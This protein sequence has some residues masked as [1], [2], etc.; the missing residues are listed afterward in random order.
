MTTPCSHDDFFRNIW[1]KA[2]VFIS[3][4]LL[5]Q[6]Y[7]DWL[8]EERILELLADEAQPDLQYGFN[9]DVTAYNGQ[10]TMAV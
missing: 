5:R 7:S 3:R 1:Q 2:P 9:L 6:W 4:P 10:V 8:S